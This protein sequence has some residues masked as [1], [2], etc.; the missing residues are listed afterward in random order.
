MAP[1]I[2]SVDVLFPHFTHLY[3]HEGAIL[4]NVPSIQRFVDKEAIKYAI[5]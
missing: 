3:N 5:F 2:K 1:S 4:Y